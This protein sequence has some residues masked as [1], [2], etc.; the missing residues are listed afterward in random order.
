MED[1]KKILTGLVAA[2]L[3]LTAAN[4]YWT[5]SLSKKINPDSGLT[6]TNNNGNTNSAAPTT[7]QK[8]AVVSGDG[9]VKGSPDAPVTII[10]FSDFQ[11]PYCAKAVV[12][13]Q[14]ALPQVY[15]QYIKAGK[16]KLVFRNYPLPFHENAQKAAEAASCAA[17]QNK[18]WEYHDKLFAN[19]TALSVDNLKQYA[20][21]FGLDT[22]KFNDCLDSGK[23][24]AQVQK[25]M[26]DGASYGVSGTPS[27]FVF[28]G[29]L[30][31]DPQ[32]IQTQ[33]QT[34]QYIIDLGNSNA[35]IIGAQPF[36]V[37][38]KIIE[39]ELKK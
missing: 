16:V 2:A 12:G 35:M 1:N 15:E 25:E 26:T 4:L 29:S 11:C 6:A 14:A 18:F 30:S 39:E 8:V 37:F 21:N 17:E 19:Q 34:G 9:P 10:E 28:K 13:S 7:G 20:K 27:F 5:F 24:T 31:V 23:T 32:Y 36:S 22:N 3:I 38:Q 33:A